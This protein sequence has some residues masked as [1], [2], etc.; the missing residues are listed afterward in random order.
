M[1]MDITGWIIAIIIAFLVLGFS[2]YIMAITATNVAGAAGDPAYSNT[3]LA[4][5]Y[6][7][8]TILNV[9]ALGALSQMSSLLAPLGI[10]VVAGI[11]IAVLLG[12]F[13]QQRD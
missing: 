8:A 13:G 12:S 10:V 1:K 7:A 2:A 6:P 9:T 4:F 11:I 5:S 3:S